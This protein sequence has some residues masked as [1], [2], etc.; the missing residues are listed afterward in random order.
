MKQSLSI[1]DIVI[2]NGRRGRV[3]AAQEKE[4]H[5]LLSTHIVACEPREARRIDSWWNT[6]KMRAAFS[7]GGRQKRRAHLARGAATKV[8]GDRQGGT[9]ELSTL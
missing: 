1:G 4:I 6:R 5:V 8:R 2:L 9:H 7:S 3:V